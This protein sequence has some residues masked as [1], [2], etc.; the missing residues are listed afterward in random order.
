MPGQTAIQ[1]SHPLPWPGAT[2]LNSWSVASGDCDFELSGVT[3]CQRGGRGHII[4]LCLRS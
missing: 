3:E 2:G 4:L 1:Q